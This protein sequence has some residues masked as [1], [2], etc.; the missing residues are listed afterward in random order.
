MKED[1]ELVVFDE[2]YRVKTNTLIAEHKDIEAESQT[3]KIFVPK[4]GTTAE[5]EDGSKEIIANKEI[6]VIDTVSYKDLKPEREYTVSGIL[7]DKATGSPFL[8]ADGN[9]VVG[10]TVFTRKNQPALWKLNS[11]LMPILYKRIRKS[12]YLKIFTMEMCS[13]PPMQT[14][15]TKAKRSQCILCTALLKY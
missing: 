4:I 7:M 11:G 5:F 8:D 9:I 14:L 12:S 10:E 6:V 3:V 2:L 13:L 1:T 15:K